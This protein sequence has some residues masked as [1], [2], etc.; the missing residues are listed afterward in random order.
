MKSLIYLATVLLFLIYGC[1]ENSNEGTA[2]IPKDILIN[3]SPWVMNP[4]Y[5][6][7]ISNCETG[8]N[9]IQYYD[10][11]YYEVYSSDGNFY[12]EGKNINDCSFTTTYTQEGT[13]IISDNT[14]IVDYNVD[15][16]SSTGTIIKL[17]NNEFIYTYF[18]V[19]YSLIPKKQ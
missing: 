2:F 16:Q 14:A 13:W 4:E 11:T 18:D 10:S 17:N 12:V 15:G 8:G 9:W 5:H 19:T 7:N 1:D 6:I 3:N